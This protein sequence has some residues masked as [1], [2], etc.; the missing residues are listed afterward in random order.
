MPKNRTVLRRVDCFIVPKAF[1]RVEPPA[2]V[3]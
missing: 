2:S 3:T 1:P